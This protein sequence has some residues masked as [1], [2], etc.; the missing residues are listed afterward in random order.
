MK[1]ISYVCLGLALIAIIGSFVA[2][3]S[4]KWALVGDMCVAAGCLFAGTGMLLDF[5][6]GRK[7]TARGLLAAFLILGILSVAI[8]IP[9]AANV[10]QDVDCGP[11]EA[12]LTDCEVRYVGISDG[13]ISLHCYLVG[14]NEDGNE[15]K[16]QISGSDARR[17]EGVSVVEVKYYP[18]TM[19]AVEVSAATQLQ[20]LMRQQLP[21]GE[22]IV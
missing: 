3:A 21:V 20:C 2:P 18:N 4:G 14:K 10:I 16:I 8:S 5:I 12:V 7:T 13:I 9:I 6:S 11:T 22:G 19:R 1:K 17:L 15:V